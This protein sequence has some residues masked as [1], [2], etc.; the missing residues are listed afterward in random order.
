MPAKKQQKKFGEFIREQREA[1]GMSLRALA[2]AA[3]VDASHLLRVE[4]D[5]KP[6]TDK[7]ARR[8]AD[9]LNLDG[10]EVAAR[11]LGP[12]PSLKTYLRISGISE[13][14]AKRELDAAFRDVANGRGK[15]GAK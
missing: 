3:D 14:Q 7:L 11:A 13:A 8:L 4:R 5:E 9:A 1:A 10:D 15:R 12:L 6:A 2:E